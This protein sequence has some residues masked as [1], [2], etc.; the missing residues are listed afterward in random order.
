MVSKLGK[1]PNGHKKGNYAERRG[2]NE[3]ILRG[4]RGQK[5]VLLSILFQAPHI[6]LLYPRDWWHIRVAVV[7]FGPVQDCGILPMFH[8]RALGNGLVSHKVDA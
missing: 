1:Y 2:R 8:S 4:T 6:F 3:I 7:I 5:C